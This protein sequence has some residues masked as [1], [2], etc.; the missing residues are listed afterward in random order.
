MVTLLV[1]TYLLLTL[2][3]P[4]P[5]TPSKTPLLSLDFPDPCIIQDAPSG[6]WYAF[7]TG[8]WWTP[9]PPTNNTTTTTN[10]TPAADKA[11]YKNIQAASAPSPRGPWTYLPSANPLPSPGVWATSTQT[12]APSLIQL[13]SSSYVLYYAAQLAA[14]NHSSSSSSYHCIGAATSSSGS[15][16]GPYTPLPEPVICPLE[17]GGAI[18][19]AGFLDPATGRRYLVYKVDGNAMGAGGECNNGVE[20]FQRTPIVLQ[21]V[22]RGDGGGLGGG[23][24]EVFDRDGGPEGVDGPLVEAP[25]LFFFT[26]TTTAVGRGEGGEESGEGGR[27]VLFYSNHCWD[28]PG[29]SVNYAVAEGNV[30]GPYKRR[31]ERLIG[32]GDGF[33]VTAPGGAASV[34]GG[35]WMVFH[36][37]CPQG[38]C[39]FGAEMEVMGDA[40]VVS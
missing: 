9:P 14:G 19:P 31:T 8:G 3:L 39:L 36:G 10:S 11:T 28:G 38:R 40:V 7:A 35:R 1:P 12:W 5:T 13:N 18:D 29:Y 30:T 34:P 23:G 20:P 21:E 15:I 16:L 2:L 33:N 4:P 27:Y 32:T 24:V 25:D 22:D 17:K 6:T 37:D 26:T